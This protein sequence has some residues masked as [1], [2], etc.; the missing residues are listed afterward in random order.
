MNF[1][2]DLKLSIR[3]GA[4]F[5][6]VLLLLA[7][8]VVLAAVDLSQIERHADKI[9]QSDFPKVEA[10]NVI[11]I[12]TRDN[13]KLV[14][15]RF[16]AADAAHIDESRHAFAENR[17]RIDAAI[18]VLAKGLYTDGGKAMLAKINESRAVYLSSIEKID[19]QLAAGDRDGASRM[20]FAQT[21]PALGKLHAAVGVID[22]IA[23][24]VVAS[25][26][27][28]IV[29]NI[30]S[31]RNT[32]LVVGVLSV[33]VGLGFAWWVTRSITVP[34]NRAVTLARS[35]AAGDLTTE[36]DAT[37]QDEVGQLLAALRDMNASLAA[38]VAR[39]RENADSIAT[40][41]AQIAT[42]N[43]DL[44]QRTEEQASSL[45]ETAASMEQLTSTVQQNAATAGQANELASTASDA[46]TAGGEVVGQVV[47]TMADITASSKRIGDIIAVIDGIAFQTNILALNAAVEAARAGEQG[48]GF[49]VV[50]AEVRSLAQRSAEAAREIKNLIGQSVEKVEAGSKLVD[51]AGKSMVDIVT[52]VKRVNDLIAEISAAGVEQSSGITQVGQAV[53]QLDHVTQQNAALVEESA[54]AAESLKQQAAELAEVVSVFK[55]AAGQAAGVT[56]HVPKPGAP[57]ASARPTGIERRGPNRA[58][59]VTRPTFGMRAAG[60]AEATTT[61]QAAAVDAKRAKTGTAVEWEEF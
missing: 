59:N 28:E 1:L 50:A 60:A 53:S 45:Q 26:G 47:S 15:E 21:L 57:A 4:G 55:V 34:I 54:A 5:G 56:G 51:D 3:L 27:K 31:A 9:V 41:S 11:K 22:D 42:G 14:M 44:S 7:V 38:I 58:T 23:A 36:L 29:E 13:S 61:I 10:L 52:Q 17:Q 20:L 40:G 39:V 37:G 32:M 18:G 33:L 43:A 19:A 24:K 6:A 2:N 8:M 12:Y 30:D 25:G 48:R 16:L 35:I 49:A 46:A